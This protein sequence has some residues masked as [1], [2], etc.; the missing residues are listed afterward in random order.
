MNNMHR[1]LAAAA[2][3][4]LLSACGGSDSLDN[5][6]D[7]SGL[8]GT[9]TVAAASDATLNGIYSGNDV[10]LDEVIK[11][12]P[13]GGDPETCRFRFANLFQQPGTTRNM[14]GD[15]RYIPGS[16]EVRTSFVAINGVEFR[17]QGMTPTV[18]AD[19]ANNRIN[20]TGAVLTSTSG[21]GR[22]I[23][24]NGFVPMRG[25]RPSGC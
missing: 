16:N 22:T 4:A 19:R 6:V 1:L 15:I 20:F 3:A 9:M 2:A 18:Q 5:D 7:P 23:T 10:L 13:V 8:S 25:D 21:D 17:Q 14:G 11:F 12:N 24:L